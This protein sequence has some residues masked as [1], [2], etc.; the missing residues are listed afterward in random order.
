MAK[1]LLRRTKKYISQIN[2]QESYA[3]FILGVII[4]IVIGLL[5]ANFIS[6][7]NQDIGTGEQVTKTEETQTQEYEIAKGDSLSVISKKFYE[8]QNFWP[9]LARENKIQ[10]PNLIFAKT[11]IVIPPKSEAEKIIAQLTQTTYKVEKGDTLFKIAEKVYGDGSK[12]PILDR[13]NRVGRLAN[14]NPL[15]FADSTIVIPR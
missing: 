2:W 13:A 10:N 9:V 4:V 3:T 5:V 12:W 11:K 15:I 1:G 8:N 7:K 14:G 6:K